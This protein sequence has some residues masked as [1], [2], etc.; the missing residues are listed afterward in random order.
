MVANPDASIVAIWLL[1]K[2]A[3]SDVVVWVAQLV[4]A[5]RFQVAVVCFDP[6]RHRSRPACR[7]ATISGAAIKRSVSNW[8]YGR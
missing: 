8:C 7:F 6:G 4:A 3:T 2:F 1:P 5:L